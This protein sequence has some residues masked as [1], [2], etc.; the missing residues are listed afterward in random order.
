MQLVEFIHD[1]KIKTNIICKMH[2]NI[3]CERFLADH[4]FCWKFRNMKYILK[5]KKFLT[6]EYTN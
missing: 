5:I 6:Y 4:Y 1:W 2:Y 3:K